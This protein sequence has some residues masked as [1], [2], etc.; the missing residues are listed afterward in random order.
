MLLCAGVIV[1]KALIEMTS[2]T[3]QQKIKRLEDERRALLNKMEPQQ[4]DDYEQAMRLYLKTSN[5]HWESSSDPESE[6][7]NNQGAEEAA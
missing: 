5:Y 3:N 4:R 7:G 1:L 6:P 2:E